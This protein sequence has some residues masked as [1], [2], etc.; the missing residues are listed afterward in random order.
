MDQKSKSSRTLHG[1]VG[2]DISDKLQIDVAENSYA[3][4]VHFFGVPEI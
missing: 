2:K 4:K 3:F 1:A